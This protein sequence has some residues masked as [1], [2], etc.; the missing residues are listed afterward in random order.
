MKVFVVVGYNNTRVYDVIRLR[1][2]ARRHY[3]AGLLL[4]AEAASALDS[5]AADDIIITSLAES[6]LNQSFQLV[7]ERLYLK[8]FHPIGILPFS[9]RGILLGARLANAYGLPGPSP[10][11]ARIG[12]DKE[13]FRTIDRIAEHSSN[14]RSIG[15]RRIKTYDEFLAC[16][17]EM[18]GKAFVKPAGEG[19]SRGC[20]VVED[21]AHCAEIWPQ[22]QR[23]AKDGLIVEELVQDAREYSWDYV[24]GTSW[25]T[26]KETTQDIYRAEI[27]Q[28]VPARLD[29]AQEK[30]IHEAGC[31]MRRLSATNH[32]AFHNEVFLR[33]DGTTA[34]VEVNMRPGGMHIWDLACLSFASF[35][36]WVLWLEWAS[37]KRWMET[38]ACTRKL[39]SG[40]RMLKAPKS[41]KVSALPDINHC[42]G[43]STVH[44]IS[45]SIQEGS[46]VSHHITDNHAFIG[47]MIFSNSDYDSL[48]TDLRAAAQ[49]FEDKIEFEKQQSFSPENA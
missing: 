11:E 32:G 45:F 8:N 27:Q 4:V 49:Y 10:R 31:H 47:H 35:D 44:E 17:E 48:K 5:Q 20:F 6:M 19:A 1:D 39:Y 36:P 14:Y 33:Q 23:Y 2:L 16:T 30:A 42:F 37:G 7:T 9:D 25:I 13:V 24:A 3:Q 18:G 29:A 46:T 40:I 41:G 22:I 12:V 21:L 43:T 38:E 28:I 15:F 26:E 34:A